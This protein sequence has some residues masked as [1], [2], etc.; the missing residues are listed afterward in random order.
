VGSTST[1]DHLPTD[2]RARTALLAEVGRLLLAL[3]RDPRVPWHAKAF[4]AAA[5]GYAAVP[6]RL[7]PGPFGRVASGLGGLD[8]TLVVLAAVRYLVAS[9]GY[10]VVRELWT[11]TDGGFAVVLLAAGVRA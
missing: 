3:G 4:A 1:P 6:G 11:G 10:D 8:D 9:A 5:V 7:L 2:P